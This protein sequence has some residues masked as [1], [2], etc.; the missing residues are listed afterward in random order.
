MASK[1][2]P[3]LLCRLTDE[4]GPAMAV[5]RAIGG[6]VDQFNNDEALARRVGAEYTLA[7]ARAMLEHFAKPLAAQGSGKKF[8]FVYCS[9]Y[10]AEWD[11]KK[12]LWFMSETRKIKVTRF[13]CPPTPSPPFSG[14]FQS[15]NTYPYRARPKAAC[16]K[17]RTRT[18]MHGSP[19]LLAQRVSCR[20]GPRH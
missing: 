12:R 5:R 9:G 2:P 20:E 11:Q 3:V 14:G 7:A 15:S 19:R 10:L 16:A 4:H 8:C 6:R 1:I 18:G 17:S 13:F